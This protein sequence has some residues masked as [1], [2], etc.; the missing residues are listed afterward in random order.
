MNAKEYKYNNEIIE[1]VSSIG[2][3]L[4][5]KY[6]DSEERITTT[7]KELKECGWTLIEEAKPEYIMCT[8]IRSGILT[9]EIGNISI[10][11]LNLEKEFRVFTDNFSIETY[12]KWVE[13]GM[14]IDSR[15][16]E[17]K[18]KKYYIACNY[19]LHSIESAVIYDF[20]S[21]EPMCGCY[22]DNVKVYKHSK[23]PIL[24]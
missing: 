21:N 2:D 11:S 1:V 19:T 14:E 6:K 7:L 16:V 3:N 5:V 18:G 24:F 4:V 20:E 10:A 23:T 13:D 17:F 15:T 12:E 8:N 22:D 9:V